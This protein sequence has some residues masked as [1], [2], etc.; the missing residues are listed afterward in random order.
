MGAPSDIEQL[1]LELINETRL[2]PLGNAARYLTSYAPLRSSNPSIQNAINFFGVDGAALLAAYQGLTPVAPLAW[3][4]ALETAASKHNDAM[5]ASGTQTHQAPGEADFGTRLTNEGYN[6]QTAAE[7]VYAYTE[8]AL[9]GH[10]GFMID[11]GFGPGGMQSPAGHRDTIM[12][13]SLSEVGIAVTAENSAANPLGPLVMTQDF[14]SRGRLFALGVAYTDT[15]QNRFYSIGE[16]RSDLTISAGSTSVTSSSSGGY[17]LEV[18]QGEHLFSLSG[19]GLT[20]SVAVRATL[21]TGN[22]KLD[23][24]DGTTLLTSASVLVDGAITSVRGLGVFG[25]TLRTGAG[26]QQITGTA[27]EDFIDGGAGVDVLGGGAGNDIYI[28]DVSGETITEAAG[29]GQDRV[30]ADG[31]YGLNPGAEVETL[32]TRTHASTFAINLSGNE[33][34]QILFGNFGRNTLDG[35][36]GA[37]TLVGF[38]GDDLYI[39]D[40]PGDIIVETAGGG[41]DRV[42]ADATYILSGGAEV[43]ILSTRTHAATFAISLTGNEYG[44]TIQGNFGA[45]TLDGRDGADT[46]I[47]FGGDDL[48][49]VDHIGDV[50]IEQAGGGNDR[51]VADVSYVLRSGSEVETISTRT[52]AA[53]EAINLTGNEFTQTIQGNFGIN[54]LDG[55]GGADTLIGFG[56]NDLYII[57]HAGDTVIEGPGDGI[58]R[59]VA[60]VNYALNAGA[61]VETLSSRTHAA[62]T[63][64]NLTGNEFGQTIHGTFG[65]NVIA[66]REGNDSLFGFAGD[67]RFVFA[68]G[69]GQDRIMDFDADPAGGQ[70][71]IDLAAYGMTNAMFANSV[72]ITV[73][74]A[75]TLVTIG[76]DVIRLVGVPTPSVDINDFLI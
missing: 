53:T 66:G 32:T 64:L 17:S 52:H 58:D 59:V 40:H 49:I 9:H 21:D 4:N 37:D 35:R 42:V 11:W 30:I 43:E 44:Q 6:F 36:G 76:A 50:V 34:G 3:N 68:A 48:Y 16:G 2:D 71:K 46:L 57:D 60:D 20:G 33:L 62:T 69:F 5:I 23:V 12:N 25:L 39:V 19:G 63:A 13:A 56:G 27:G 29:G 72:S 14:G 10:A 47:G 61:E 28:V 31:N 65:A 1:F 54:K 22:L 38:A 55:R 51:L 8:S 75:D 45:N 41:A 74:G 24:V 73:S 7:N 67:D 15:D 18:G 26:T 70:D